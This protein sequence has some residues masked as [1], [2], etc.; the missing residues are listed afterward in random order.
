MQ[1]DQKLGIGIQQVLESGSGPGLEVQILVFDPGVVSIEWKKVAIATEN[2][3]TL[4]Y[5][6]YLPWVEAP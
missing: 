4:Y 1:C 5:Y 3:F 6:Y 2:F